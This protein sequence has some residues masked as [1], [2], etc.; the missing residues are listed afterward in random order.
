MGLELPLALSFQRTTSG[1]L[2]QPSNSLEL[3]S[4]PKITVSLN[5]AQDFSEENWDSFK[6]INGQDFYFRVEEFHGGSGGQVYTLIVWKS[7]L[8]DYISLEQTI[9]AESLNQA[10]FGLGWTIIEGA[11]ILVSDVR[12]I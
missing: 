7:F 6:E 5:S 2:I 9:Q 10:D 12:E 4:P 11:K 8:E 1:F 3:R